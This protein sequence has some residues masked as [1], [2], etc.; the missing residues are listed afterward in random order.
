MIYWCGLWWCTV[1]TV[2]TRQ[3]W[4]SVAMPQAPLDSQGVCWLRSACSHHIMSLQLSP[5]N[6]LQYIAVDIE[7]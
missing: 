6:Q 3:K 2:D 7:V 4:Y 1:Q 5:S